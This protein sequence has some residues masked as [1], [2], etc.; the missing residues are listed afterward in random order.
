MSFKLFGDCSCTPSWSHYRAVIPDPCLKQVPL[1]LLFDT[2][3]LTGPIDSKK[4]LIT[5]RKEFELSHT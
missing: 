2:T 4:S 1:V 5:E 3:T